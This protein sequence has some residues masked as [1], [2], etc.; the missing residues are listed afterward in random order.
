MNPYSI[1]EVRLEGGE[2]LPLL[3]QDDSLGLPVQG[4]TEYC[5][6]KLRA[7]G[8][9]R[10]SIRQR[11]H[12]LEI[13]LSFLSA[14]KID[15]VA[16]T[17]DQ[18]FLT[19]NELVALADRCRERRRPAPGRLVIKAATAAVR[20]STALDYIG[21]VAEPVIARITNSRQRESVNFSLQRFL[22]R[23]RSVAP[24]PRGRDAHIDGERHGLQDDQRELFLRVIRPG[25]PGNPFAAAFQ[26]RNY[27]VLLTAFK[28]GARSGE[29]RGLKKL[30]LNLDSEP[31]ELSII[32]RYHDKDDHR[33][34]PAAVKTNGRILHI[35]G[36]M[37]DALEGWLQ[38]RRVRA[39]WPRAHRNPFVFVN[40]FGDPIEG[41]GYRK[42]VEKL[43]SAHPVLGS[44]CHHV[45]RHDW[46]DR[47][48]LLV[49]KDG[50]DSEKALHE[51][52]YAMGW[53]YQSKMPQRYAKLAIARA[54]N[55][56]ILQLQKE[57][58]TED[59]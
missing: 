39:S 27:A 41:R 13:I 1:R 58:E 42:I 32:P 3:V 46:N 25:D 47:W 18:T 30:D 15:L 12:A 17:V 19:L 54:A 2:R 37:R 50:A 53:S 5:L 49:E 44:F 8:L 16:R 40:R 4:A 10:S 59:E 20:Y 36:E 34:D 48:V 55:K 45:L 23:A 9:R 52:K 33:L 28:L 14:N 24:K 57:T 51:Q 38:D 21:W 6:T 56:R 22:K 26:V 7:C 29:I 31:A 43:R 11:V 35:D